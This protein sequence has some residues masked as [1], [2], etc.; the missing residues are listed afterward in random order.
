MRKD[1]VENVAFPLLSVGDSESA[2][3]VFALAFCFSSPADTI[4][5]PVVSWQLHWL[6]LH[7]LSFRIMGNYRGK[8]V[9]Q[10]CNKRFLSPFS[11]YT[12]Y[13]FYLSKLLKKLCVYRLAHTS[14][15]N[16]KRAVADSNKRHSMSILIPSCGL[17]C[18][19][20]VESCSSCKD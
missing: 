19:F 12:L 13:L 20:R 9:A 1:P 5:P 8:E 14:H 3:L 16:W 6:H 4:T 11:T 15:M 17:G 18:F 2:L 7:P 10:K